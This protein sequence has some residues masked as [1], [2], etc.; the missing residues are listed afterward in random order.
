MTR[1]RIGARRARSNM[2]NGRRSANRSVVGPGGPRIG[3][4]SR[5]ERES[6][7]EFSDFGCTFDRYLSDLCSPLAK[8][9]GALG[10]A[11]TFPDDSEAELQEVRVTLRR[12]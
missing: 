12:A 11:P 7:R 10:Q 9:I 3:R 6:H 1:E 2:V 8:R 5:K 4:R